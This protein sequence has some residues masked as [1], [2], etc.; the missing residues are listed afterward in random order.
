MQ[1]IALRHRSPELAFL[2]A[3][4]MLWGGWFLYRSSFVSHEGRRFFCLFDDAMISMTYARNLVEG[5]GLNWAREGEPVEGF[6]HPL[7]LL[8]MIAVNLLPIPL[9]IRSL[10]LQLLSLLLLA[11]NVA[12]V[13][14]LVL[15]HFGPGSGMPA[16]VLTAFYYPLSYWSL[17]GMETGLQALL[18]LL[19]VH[20]ALDVAE[21]G[22][23]RQ[24]A[25]WLVCAA[26]YLVRM[27]M[28]LMV[29][30]VQGYVLVRSG[31]RRVASS[32]S[33][34]LGLAL[35]L[36]LALGYSLFRWL[37]FGTSCPTPTTS[38]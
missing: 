37:Y 22:R 26:A 30:A 8:P 27:D 12:A 19:A 25:L 36:I 7:W 6:T 29:V 21:A 17:M 34:R 18:T 16:A 10:P 24:L 13:R 33:W 20:L 28:L 31:A 1:P 15:D 4:L 11:A 5:Y 3:L 2:L 32:R 9:E 35:F 38:S 23:D 14:R